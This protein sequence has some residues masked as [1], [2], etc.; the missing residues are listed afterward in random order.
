MNIVDCGSGPPLVLIPGLQGRWEYMRPTVEALATSFRVITFSLEG[1]D[2]DSYAEQVARALDAAGSESAVVCGQSFGGMIAVHFAARSP[3]RCK[4]LVLASTPRPALTLRKRHQLYLRAPWILGPLFLAE[5]PFRVRHELRAALAERGARRRFS[6]EALRTF[7]R[8]P[9]SLRKM[10]ARARLVTSDAIVDDCRR[11]D[12]PTLIVTGEAHLDYV[13]PV[14]GT[15]EYERL[16]PRTRRVVLD[17]TGHLGAMTRPH[18]F[19]ALIR[20][21]VEGLRDAAA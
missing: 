4:A 10:A 11:I 1:T 6:R 21:F 18:E 5:T 19:A 13:V 20:D 2:F 9:L 7:F 8:A 12:A 14:D 17:S 16:I 3:Q 15:A